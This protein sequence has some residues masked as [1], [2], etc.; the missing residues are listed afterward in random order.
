[1]STATASQSKA[2]SSSPYKGITFSYSGG[3]I[4][5]NR[6]V[7]DREEWLKT[8]QWDTISATRHVPID[9]KYVVVDVET[10][11][12][13]ATKPG[14]YSTGRVVEMAWMLVD[15]KDDCIELKQ[16][17]IKPYG[18][19]EISNKAVDLHGITTETAISKGTEAGLVFREFVS[20]LQTLP[21]DGFVIAYN[22]EHEHTVFKN[23]FNIDQI[24]VWDS[25]PKCDTY[26][27]SL[28]KHLPDDA[29]VYKKTYK[30]R[31]YGTTLSNLHKIMYP[32]QK[33]SYN[34]VHFASN[35]VKMTWDIFR[36]YKQYATNYELKWKHRIIVPSTKYSG[37]SVVTNVGSLN[38]Y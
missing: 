32:S 18:Y 2:F 16:Y 22:M 24:A 10:H 4:T 28:W 31:N 21:P 3:P 37:I 34:V 13:N 11:D 12:W 9:V 17:L 19:E 36:Y 6:A 35:D 1:M 25:V 5:C 14:D 23:S 33:E 27:V 29:A 8:N 15:S 7:K 30:S 20:I 26:P 38:R